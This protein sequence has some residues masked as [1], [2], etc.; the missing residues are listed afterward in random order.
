M[1]SKLQ[2]SDFVME[3]NKSFMKI[4]TRKGPNDSNRFRT[5][6][7]LVRKRAQLFNITDY[8]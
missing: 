6:H 3:K 5:H 7:H 2:T 4:F 8:G 1:N